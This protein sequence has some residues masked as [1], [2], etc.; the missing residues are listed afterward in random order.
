M[1]RCPHCYQKVELL[2]G[3]CPVCT[4]HPTKTYKVMQKKERLIRSKIIGIYLTAFAHLSIS[5][6]LPYLLQKES[7]WSN[8][9]IAGFGILHLIIFILLSKFNLLGYRIA[10]AYYFAYGMV[11]VVT[12]QRSNFGEQGIGL[13]LCFIALYLIGNQTAKSLFD[14]SLPRPQV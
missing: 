6:T 1:M 9:A 2:D 3:Y 11:C 13:I 10:V 14:R 4:L 7:D 8:G 5:I 12:I